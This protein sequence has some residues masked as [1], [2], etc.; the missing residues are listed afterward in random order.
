[1]KRLLIL[2]FLTLLSTHSN[3]LFGQDVFNSEV[4]VKRSEN[5]IVMTGKSCEVL[6]SEAAAISAWSKKTKPSP[7]KCLGDVCSIDITQIVPDLVNE[8][9]GV[10][11]AQAGPNCLNTTL[12]SSGLISNLRYTTAKEMGL[13]LSSPLCTERA[14]GENKKPGDIVVFKENGDEI[15]AFVHVSK[16][17]SFSRNGSR[18]FPYTFQS[19]ETGYEV[20]GVKKGCEDAYKT[21]APEKNCKVWTNTFSCISFEEYVKKNPITDKEQQAAL[22]RLEENECTLSAQAFSKTLNQEMLE[23]AKVSVL[24]LQKLAEKRFDSS[25]TDKDKLFW[26]SIA[27]KADASYS[28]YLLLSY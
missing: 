14:R 8:T 15:H 11:P 18:H 16:N 4:Q 2:S 9:Q 28:Q 27:V 21:P 5:Q 20:Y 24:A 7:C 1:M 13:W 26:K 10:C 23:L 3:F 22:N 19:P 25:V 17:L 6:K 12:V